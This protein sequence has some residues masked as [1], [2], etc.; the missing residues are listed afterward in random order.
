MSRLPALQTEMTG[1]KAKRLLEG[2]QAKLE[3]TPNFLRV[4][5][6]S[7]AVLEGYLNFAGALAGGSLPAKL[8]EQI[9]IAVGERN[10][11]QYC[12]SA[13]TALGKLAGLSEVELENA[14]AMRSDSPEDAA[15][16]EFVE[17]LMARRGHVTEADFEKVRSAGFSESDIAE[18]VAHTA[19]N[20]FTNYFNT[21]NEVEVD[22]PK[23]VLKQAA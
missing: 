2:V 8:R 17:L 21:A 18:I 12:L 3:M 16:L 22:F 4:M 1:S 11:C 15:A 23:V 6:N 9:A 13:H 5:A 20:I 7:P 19:L 10:G 14:R